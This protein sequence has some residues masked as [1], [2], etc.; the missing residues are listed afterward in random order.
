M[1]YDY[2]RWSK[3]LVEEFGLPSEYM[4]DA[5][6]IWEEHIHPID[7][8]AYRDMIVIR[9]QNCGFIFTRNAI[10]VQIVPSLCL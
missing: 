4:Y 1:D 6:T 7:K 2:S 3:G 8:Q 10:A 9:I 5:A